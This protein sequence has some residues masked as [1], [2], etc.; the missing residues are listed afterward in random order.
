M[1]LSYYNHFRRAT[2]IFHTKVL[3][4]KADDQKWE[5]EDE[6]TFLGGFG[7][8]YCSG[9]IDDKTR[10]YKDRGEQIMIAYRRAKTLLKDDQQIVRVVHVGDA[11][12]D[13]LAAK[14]FY[15]TVEDEVTVSCIGVATGKFDKTTLE[16]LIGTPIEGRWEP[17]VL[18]KGLSDENF[19]KHCKIL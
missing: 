15:E 2:G 11:P 13:V 14:H 8:D 12:A 19:I 1:I 9:D 4:R 3:S 18:E 10:I 5:G 7:S 17:I 6:T 16:N